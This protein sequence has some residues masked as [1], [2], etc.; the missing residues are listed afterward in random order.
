MRPFFLSSQE[1]VTGYIF[2]LCPGLSGKIGFEVPFE[3]SNSDMSIE[4]A[5]EVLDR[6]KVVK[7]SVENESVQ[8]YQKVS[9]GGQRLSMLSIL[10]MLIRNL[11]RFLA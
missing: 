8:V 7:I 10:S 1:S 9:I 6:L 2:H 11:R 4:E 3:K 5:F